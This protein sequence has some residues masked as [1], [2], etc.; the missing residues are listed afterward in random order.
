MKNT[1]PNHKYISKIRI[2][3]RL[4]RQDKAIAVKN[5]EKNF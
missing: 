5:S 1:N 2:K 3:H 4:G